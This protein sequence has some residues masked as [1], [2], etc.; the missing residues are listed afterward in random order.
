[1]TQQAK[2]ATSSRVAGSGAPGNNKI[3][4]CCSSSTAQC[5]NWGKN[6]LLTLDAMSYLLQLYE[7]IALINTI[8]IRHI[9]PLLPFIATTG[10]QDANLA[11][12]AMTLV[13]RK[14]DRWK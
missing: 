4:L 9:H 11:F 14:Q 10:I 5:R 6:L 8:I 1:M 3:T 2:H 7:L 13:R 12:I